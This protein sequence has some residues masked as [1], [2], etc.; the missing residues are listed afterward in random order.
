[1]IIPVTIV[2]RLYDEQGFDVTGPE[3]QTITFTEREERA[4]LWQVNAEI[5]RDGRVFKVSG[6][7]WRQDGGLTVTVRRTLHVD[8]REERRA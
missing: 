5:E 7:R 2:V 1:M 8:A 3:P 6:L 4:M